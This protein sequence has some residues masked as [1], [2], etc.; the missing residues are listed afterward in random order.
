MPPFLILIALTLFFAVIGP[1][2]AA[3]ALKHATD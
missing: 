2:G 3:L 1:L